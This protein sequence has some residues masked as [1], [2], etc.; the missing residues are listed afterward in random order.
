MQAAFEESK[1]VIKEK[2]VKESKKFFEEYIAN[3]FLKEF[4]IEKEKK[5]AFQTSLTSLIKNFSKEYM[6]LCNKFITFFKSKVDKIIKEFDIKDNN[7]IEHINFIVIGKAGIGKSTFI[8]E[9][10]LLPE[11]KRA[12]EGKGLSVTHESNLYVSD[13]LTMVRMWDTQGLDYKFSLENILNEIKRLVKVSSD[14][15]PDH[16][17][18][19]IL[20]CT[21]GDRF[22]NEDGELIKK[23]MDLYP[24]NNLPVIITQLR[25]YYEE[26][27]KMMEEIIRKIL[28]NY[29]GHEIAQKIEIRSILSRDYQPK[30]S[31]DIYKAYGIPELLRLS[32]DL[33]GRSISS[34]TCG[35]IKSI[36]EKQCE[37]FLNK[38]NLYVQNLLKNE[39]EILEVAKSSFIFDIEEF[40][41]D[42]I[43]HDIKELS[44]FNIYK[45]LENT[46]YFV[47]NFISNLTDKFMDIFNYLQNENFQIDQKGI[48]KENQNNIENNEKEDN[49]EEEKEKEDNDEEEKEKEEENEKEEEKEIEENE[50]EENE[51]EENE[52]E[53]ND[54][55]EKKEQ[56]NNNEQNI[57]INENNHQEI[58]EENNGEQNE[59]KQDEPPIEH[60]IKVILKKIRNTLNIVSDKKFNNKFEERF[61]FYFKEL[62][63]EQKKKHQEF[64]DNTYLINDQEDKENFKEILKPLFKNEFFKIFFCIILRLFMINLDE[65]FKNIILTEITENKNV[66]KILYQKAEKSLK[67][68]TENLKQNLITE[69]NNVMKYKQNEQK[70][71]KI[72]E[73]KK[74][75]KEEKEENKS[76]S[77]SDNDEEDFAF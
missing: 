47:E 4:E 31:N 40:E 37:N 52:K 71:K 45:N 69:L 24:L 62:T 35:A 33:M 55:E 50:I 63:E 73:E 20:Y 53:D 38:K 58:N 68:I 57:N 15:G 51:K 60:L 66:Q 18:N 43:F 44:E 65:Y 49:D 27:A 42:D 11:N 23:I 56:Y 54:E 13:K 28:E 32:F 46:N 6:A 9:S 61:T 72:E 74:E 77:E 67:N 41:L 10:L 17:I 3:T 76:K 16:Y 36:I 25:A 14:K 21:N 59:E 8:N 75:K 34:A 2:N 22:Q 19:I 39:M 48:E 29:L 26:E 1:K 64:H 7:P 70:E 5:S 30:G 12:K